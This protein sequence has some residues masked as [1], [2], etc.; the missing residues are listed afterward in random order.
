MR[1]LG[2]LSWF[3]GIRV[4]R[5][6]VQ[7]KLW[8]CQDSYIRKIATTFHLIDRKPPTTPLAVEELVPSD[9]QATP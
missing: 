8:L 2:E 9:K 4:I 7:K 5:D 1:D 3:L 6:R